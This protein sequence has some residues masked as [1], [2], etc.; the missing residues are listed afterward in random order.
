MPRNGMK[1]SAKRVNGGGQSR[2]PAEGA[3]VPPVADTEV[4]ED[5]LL[6]C[7]TFLTQYH[8]N[9]KSADVLMAGLPTPGSRLT[10][11]LFVRAAER[12]GY[13]A[14]IVKRRLGAISSFVL[15][16]VLVLHD[17]RACVLARN[18][19]KQTASVL[20]PEMGMV[21]AAVSLDELGRDYSGYAILVRPESRLDMHQI[22][23]PAER[24]L[25]WFWGAI[26]ANWWTY[27]QVALAAVFINLFGLVSP[28]FIMM[29]YD[30]VVPN[31]AIDTL[32][33]LASGVATVIA[34]DLILKTLR[35][36]FIDAAGKQTDV[37]VAC[38]I[39]DQ[40]LDMK[41]AARPAS[42]GAFANTLR[43]FETL[44]EFFT[45]ATLVAFI[46]LPFVLLFVAVL[47][48]VCG[49]LVMVLAVA[50]PIVLLYGVFIQFPLNR[51]VR[52]NF[53]ESE[54]KH[55]VL[56][57]VINGLETIK[58]VGAEARMRHLWEGVVGLTARSAQ[59]SRALS[60]SGVNVAGTV[61]QLTSVAVV[62]YGVHLIS[63][64]EITVGALIA[65]VML[66]GR[67]LAPLGQ[68]AQLL[69]RFHQSVSSLRA[70]NR[71]M[72]AP[73]ERPAKNTFLHRPEIK[74]G[75]EFKG[76]TFTYPGRTEP[77]LNSLNFAIREGEHV[78]I[79]GRVGSGK[80]TVAKIILGLFDPT[81]GTIL[82]DGTDMRQIDPA[83]LRRGIGYVAQEPFLFRGSVKDN[84]TVAEPY[85]D[86]A[87]ILDA[88]C[89][90]GI[91]E[92]VS[93][94]AVG[95][96]L[97]VGERGEGLSGG[98]RQGITVARAL[99]RKPSI[100]ILDEPTSSMDSRSE[101]AL[102]A[103]LNEYL[104]G[105]TLVLITHRASLLSFVDRIIVL[106]AGR[107]VADG[108]REQV[109]EALAAGRVTASRGES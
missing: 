95:Y 102:K 73:V 3:A 72:K 17:G 43:E 84:I 42:A 7:L 36:Y 57:E 1:T 27:S 30:R 96:D 78:G 70:L 26:F 55:G 82:F 33:V 29:V 5:P 32:W 39:F 105:R 97:P 40:V 88:A 100:L 61:Q 37:V 16:A 4:H 92:F 24:P 28:F 108:P 47:W 81:D 21:E 19:G 13:R 79:I 68:V 83:D 8:G 22:E 98:Q 34:F 89:L 14:R 87:E 71:I 20:I 6:E 109:L 18:K 46:D 2:G 91:D 101:Q 62:I 60:S 12:A 65:C 9:P 76:V 59:K 10:P 93:G 106:D 69:T 35:A 63:Q 49:P 99:L 107:I 23:E 104:H 74:G 86:D 56:V 52:A 77:A 53:K 45:S 38:R 50:I 66:G 15:P 11:N 51:V 48:V 58:T 44:R 64:G 54:Q 75:I 31:N 94:T 85:A 41:M 67:A 25:S 80:S 103:S 90:A